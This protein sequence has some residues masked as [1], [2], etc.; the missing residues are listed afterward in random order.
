MGVAATLPKLSEWTLQTLL[1][2]TQTQFLNK[3]TICAL[4]LPPLKHRSCPESSLLISFLLI[5]KPA[6]SS[7]ENQ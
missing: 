4:V 3:I 1:S 6:T 5:L 2:I 7:S